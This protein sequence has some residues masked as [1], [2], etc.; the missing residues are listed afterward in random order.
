MKITAILAIRNEE[1]YLANCLRHLVKNNIDFFIIDNESKDSSPEIYQRS[2]FSQNLVDVQIYPYRNSYPWVGL[3]QKKMEVAK[4]L[5]TD[6]IIHLD[7]DEIMHSYNEGE[8]LSEAI[9]RLDSYG[10][11]VINF[12]EF[13]FLPIE[14]NYLTDIK[15]YQPIKHYYFFAPTSPRCMRAWRKSNDLSMVD[16]GGHILKGENI[17]LSPEHLVQ[18]HYIVR[19]QEHAFTKYS[20][21]VFAPEEIARGWHRARA[22]QPEYTFL[23][24]PSRLLKRLKKIDTHELDRSDPWSTHYWKRSLEYRS[25]GS[26]SSLHKPIL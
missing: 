1:A 17:C 3:L 14:E 18:R 9:Y 20:S 12:E 7:A 25:S 21:R 15:E 22:N 26:L 2:E 13:V 24:P 10:W 8:S 4:S 5:H 19:N 16:S 23:F 6:W 11:N